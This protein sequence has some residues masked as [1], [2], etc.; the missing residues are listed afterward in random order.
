MTEFVRLETD[1]PVARLILNRPE[2]RNALSEA[3]LDQLAELQEQIS[4]DEQLRVVVLSAT[5]SV[6]CSGHDLSEMS[7]RSETEYRKLFSRCS[8]VMRRFRTL[9]QPV[10]ARV[11]SLAT[12]AGCQLVA[13]CD[14]VIAA[15]SAAF[16]TPGVK[17]GLFCT[18]PMVPLVRAIPTKA[19]MEMLLTGQP[20]SALRAYELGLVNKV[21][22]LAELDS[23]IN[24]MVKSI[25]STSMA[26]IRLGKQAFYKLLPMDEFSAYDEATEVMTQNAV[27]PHAQEGISAFLG[28]R[29]PV[30]K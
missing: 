24:E 26:T 20:I 18:T 2:R 15:D 23:A 17:I 5:G 22:P 16:A 29:P 27:H 9:P 6:F 25:I 7:G 21:V 12:A 8:Q 13:A 19:A 10:I 4:Q 3:L 28:K 11:H 14:L 30:W 1:G